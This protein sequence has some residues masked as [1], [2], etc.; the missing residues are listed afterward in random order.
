MRAAV[1]Q[2]VAPPELER[3]DPE[4]AGDDVGLAL[5]GPDELRDAEAAQGARGRLVGIHRVV[6]Q[7]DVLDVIR[8]GGGESGLLRDARADV[9][10]CPSVPEGL[11]LARNHAAVAA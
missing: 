3:V 7:R 5:V 8:S 11:D 6:V 1:A 9:R 10:V 2:G 4:G